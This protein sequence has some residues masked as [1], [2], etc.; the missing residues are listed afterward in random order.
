MILET[1]LWVYVFGGLMLIAFIAA[2]GVAFRPSLLKKVIMLSIFS[3][4]INIL[5][6]ALGFHIARP[7]PPVYPGMS[8]VVHSLPSIED[9]RAFASRAVDPIPQVLVITAVVIGLA[10]LSFL[11]YIV[12]L[13]YRRYGTLDVRVISRKVREEVGRA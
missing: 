6:V 4:A 12:V 13:V 11:T 1:V 2:Y 3:D 9:V 7:I 5:A 8:F 10:V